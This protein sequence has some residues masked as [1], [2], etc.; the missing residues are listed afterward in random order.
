M[1]TVALMINLRIFYRLDHGSRHIPN[2]VSVLIIFMVSQL[3][4]IIRHFHKIIFYKFYHFCHPTAMTAA[5][6][7]SVILYTFLRREE[8]NKLYGAR[9]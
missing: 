2:I 4:F 5:V 1:K 3:S 8:G 9:G 7:K 6:L